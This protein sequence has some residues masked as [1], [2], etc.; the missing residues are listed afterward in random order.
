MNFFPNVSGLGTAI[1]A[2][3]DDVRIDI[4]T[5]QRMERARAAQQVVILVSDGNVFHIIFL[6]VV[7]RLQR[8]IKIIHMSP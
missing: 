6:C 4:L 5:K 7:N 1:S 2:V 8:I 3:L